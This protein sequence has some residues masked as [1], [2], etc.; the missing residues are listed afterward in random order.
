MA[1]VT[2]S[3]V[4]RVLAPTSA[5]RWLSHLPCA[6]RNRKTSARFSAPSSSSPVSSRCSNQRSVPGLFTV[7]L[8]SYRTCAGGG[9]GRDAMWSLVALTGHTS[10]RAVLMCFSSWTAELLCYTDGENFRKIMQERGIY[11]TK[12]RKIFSFFGV[13]FCVEESTP[14]ITPSVQRVVPAGQK[15]SKLLPEL[16][17]YR[18]MRCT[19]HASCR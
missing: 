6:S 16:P 11:I 13:T 10:G 18:R 8:F 4:W 2:F 15:P 9:F 19:V 7:L 12:F 1:V 3:T 14:N 5:W 17:K